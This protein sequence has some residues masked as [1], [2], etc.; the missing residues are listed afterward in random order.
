MALATTPAIFSE[1]VQLPVIHQGTLMVGNVPVPT[2]VHFDIKNNLVY[3]VV[4]R[5]GRQGLEPLI[6]YKVSL[7]TY[8]I[9]EIWH[10]LSV[11]A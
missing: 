1:I 8:K 5:F 6:I 4:V 2:V 10:D 3:I 7:E 11:E 9:E